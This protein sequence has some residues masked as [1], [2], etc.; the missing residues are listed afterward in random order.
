M[1]KLICLWI[2]VGSVSAK[3]SPKFGERIVKDVTNSSIIEK[4]F[5]PHVVTEK[6]NKLS[7]DQ[8]IDKSIIENK[9]ITYHLDDKEKGNSIGLGN[10]KITFETYSRS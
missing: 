5:R 7:Y 1:T 2:I 9:T 3:P 8:I 6:V 4:V 10:I